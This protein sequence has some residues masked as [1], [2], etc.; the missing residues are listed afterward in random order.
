MCGKVCIAV[1]API[2]ADYDAH[3][4][5]EPQR[6]MQASPRHRRLVTSSSPR[7]VHA[8]ADVANGR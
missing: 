4:A 6:L 7:H 3:M 8:V 5:F 2:T 1:E